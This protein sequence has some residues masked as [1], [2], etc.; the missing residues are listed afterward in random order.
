M[1]QRALQEYEQANGWMADPFDDAPFIDDYP[2][3]PFLEEFDER[4]R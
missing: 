3:Q 4:V 2:F 1:Q